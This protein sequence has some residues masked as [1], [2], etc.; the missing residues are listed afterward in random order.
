MGSLP[1]LARAVAVRPT[2]SGYLI[3]SEVANGILTAQGL[4]VTDPKLA[5]SVGIEPGDTILTINGHSP[6]GGAFLTLV[7]LRRDP[8][9]GTVR[10]EVDRGG[11]RIERMIVIR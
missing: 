7:K 3:E 11:R 9:S 5:A 1:S 2:F 8:D 6:A 4:S 10:L